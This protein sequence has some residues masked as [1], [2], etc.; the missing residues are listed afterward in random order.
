MVRQVHGVEAAG[1][2]LAV[3]SE[4]RPAGDHLVGVAV[5]GG[6]VLFEQSI[7]QRA[8]ADA[9]TV[10]GEELHGGS[11]GTRPGAVHQIWEGAAALAASTE[12]V[13][14]PAEEA[15][16]SSPDVPFLDVDVHIRLEG[17]RD[18]TEQ[19]YRQVRSAILD[20]RLKVGDR[21]PPSRVLATELGVS[22]NTVS[23]AYE[24]LSGEGLL[25]ARQG[26]G[27]FVSASELS[28]TATSQATISSPLRP[29]AV[30]SGVRAPT[31]RP[32]DRYRYDFRLGLPDKGLFPFATW[33]RL[34]THEMRREAGNNGY[35][36]AAGHEGLRAA[37]AR[38]VGTSRALRAGPEQVVVTNGTQQALDLICRV[39]LEPGDCVV[40]EDPGYLPARQLFESLG[41]RVVTVPVDDEGMVIT[42]LPEQTRLIFTC[43]SHQMP[44]G[45]PMSMPRRHALLSWA[46]DRDTAIV[47]DDYDSEFRFGG[48]RLDALQAI[49]T[50]GRVIYV[51]T[52]SKTLDPALRLGFVVAPAAIADAL[53]AARFLSDWHSPLVVQ[54]AMAR[55]IDDGLFARH[56]H[57][58]RTIYQER[59]EILLNAL[60]GDP[61]GRLTPIPASTGLHITALLPAT[62]AAQEHAIA[63]KA[64]TVGLELYRLAMFYSGAADRSGFVLGFGSIPRSLIAEGIGHL[65]AAVA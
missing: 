14:E 29:R 44:L 10:V 56:V 30:W 37:I 25:E 52:F 57:T 49:D 27:T 5:H 17:S 28:M 8:G 46:R 58:S 24:W 23:F 36:P 55:F 11:V 40:M 60:A 32:D 33:R 63:Q 6:P 51:G 48:H 22:R 54:A 9:V 45:M 50:G 12:T 34:I 4:C 31:G 7:A 18:L 43:P 53:A 39:L 62:L 2:I 59:H 19:V 13:A 65:L 38:H 64:A 42:R 35:G 1:G 3:R 26:S 20:G 47:E 61:K 16:A 21:L 41:L 15:R